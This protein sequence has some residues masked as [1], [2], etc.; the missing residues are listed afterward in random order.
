M[1]PT[2]LNVYGTI[3]RETKNMCINFS[4]REV[5]AY[6]LERSQD[7]NTK[8]KKKKKKLGRNFSPFLNNRQVS[9]EC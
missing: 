3:V 8:P 7:N 9:Y 5:D 1:T 2:I 6:Y 4:H